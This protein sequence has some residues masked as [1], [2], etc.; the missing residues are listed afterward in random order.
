[1]VFSLKSGT[2]SKSVCSIFSSVYACLPQS[3]LAYCHKLQRPITDHSANRAWGR[4]APFL[5]DGQIKYITNVDVCAQCSRSYLRKLNP[6]LIHDTGN[7]IPLVLLA[8]NRDANFDSSCFFRG[9]LVSWVGN[10][11]LKMEERR[12]SGAT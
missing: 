11:I 12:M 1:M 4:I 10:E 5:T 8:P 2:G 7:M 6:R 9:M 3:K